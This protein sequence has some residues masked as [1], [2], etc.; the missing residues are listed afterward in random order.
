MK[1]GNF[2]GNQ[3]CMSH[4]KRPAARDQQYT[5]PASARCNATGSASKGLPVARMGL[6]RFQR[7]GGGWLGVE[8]ASKVGWRL[9]IGL[10]VEMAA[11]EKE[12]KNVILGFYGFYHGGPYSFIFFLVGRKF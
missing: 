1:V 5:L 7:G 2:S 9:N 10:I 12:K 8:D 4:S 6:V 11:G 3:R